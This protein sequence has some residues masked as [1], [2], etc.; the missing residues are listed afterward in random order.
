MRINRHI[1]DKTFALI[2][3]VVLLLSCSKTMEPSPRF[4]D[5]AGREIVFSIDQK[6]TKAG[7][8]VVPENGR[9]VCKM[10]YHSEAGVLAD[11]TFNRNDTTITWFKVGGTEG[12]SLYWNSLYQ[13][14]TTDKYGDVA[15]TRF[16][17]QNRHTHCFLAI[18]D[19]NKLY[20]DDSN[21]SLK[22]CDTESYIT[23][24]DGRYYFNTYY[25]SKSKEDVAYASMAEQPDPMLAFTQKIPEKSSVEANRVQLTF[26]HQLSQVHVNICNSGDH[27]VEL[28]DPNSIVKVQLLGTSDVAY[29]PHQMRTNGEVYP[30]FYK[31]VNLNEYTANQLKKN[32]YG[33]Y[34]SMFRS[35]DITAGAVASFEC[36][37]TG[38]LGGIRVTWKEETEGATEHEVTYHIPTANFELQ[39]G[40]NY[41]YNIELRRA[42][43][44]VLR[45]SVVEWANGN[46]YSAEGSQI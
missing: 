17:W 13:S 46:T 10:Y 40:K 28:T 3:G 33:T 26:S 9:F 1:F 35:S 12:N 41:I 39:G 29:V 38:K 7:E 36:I 45:A 16:Y 32:P 43:L 27:S 31:K 30:T 19:N 22:M 15:A 23:R 18:Y 2:S 44:S 4:D 11:S 5:I 14:A 37:A 24:S 20:T 42:T 8:S 6:G 21:G 34:F 25:V